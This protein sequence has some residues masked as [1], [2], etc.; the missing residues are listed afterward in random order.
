M[1]RPAV[2]VAQYSTERQEGD[3]ETERQEGMAETETEERKAETERQERNAETERQ[4]RMA[5]AETE[6]RKAE[7]EREERKEETASEREDETKVDVSVSMSWVDTSGCL[8]CSVLSTD[9]CVMACCRDAGCGRGCVCVCGCVWGGGRDMRRVANNLGEARIQFGDALHVDK[10]GTW[11][12]GL[13]LGHAASYLQL[14]VSPP[15]AEKAFRPWRETF[16]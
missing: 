1:T 6:E 16:C 4:E 3:A 15:S 8:R 14:G 2:C 11:L 10:D 12:R 5:E 9:G 7:T 13:P